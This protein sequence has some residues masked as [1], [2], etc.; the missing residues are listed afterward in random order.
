MISMPKI[1]KI[2]AIIFGITGLYYLN[3]Y[4]ENRFAYREVEDMLAAYGLDSKS[5]RLERIKSVNFLL[6][7]YIFSLEQDD[8]SYRIEFT[9]TGELTCIYRENNSNYADVVGCRVND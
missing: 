2:T 1:L 3:I 4:L 5:L 9:S 8:A 7:V 6:N